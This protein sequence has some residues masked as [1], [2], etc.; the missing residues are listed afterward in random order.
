LNHQENKNMSETTLFG[1]RRSLI[2]AAAA[3]L[4][5]CFLG[6][7]PLSSVAADAFPSRPIRMVVPFPPG[8]GFDSVAR[9]FAEKLSAI[10]KQTVMVDNR[11]GAGGNIGTAEVGRAPRDGYTILFANEILATNPNMYAS[12]PFD[13]IKDFAP[14]AMIATTPLVLA[15]YPGLPAKNLSELIALS[16][17]EPITFGTPGIGTSPHLF[18]ELLNLKTPLKM[19]H[20][21]YRGTAPAINDAMAGQTNAVLTSASAL[22]QQIVGGKL[23]GIAIL[24]DRRSPL[25]PDL[26][27]LAEAGI[28]GLTHDI[29]YAVLAP[30]GTPPAIVA[31]LR[32]ASMTVMR[33]P[34]LSA[35]L[36]KLGFEPVVGDDK[37]VTAMIQKDL[38]RW[39]DVI[40]EAKIQK[41]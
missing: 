26:P 38:K 5:A 2:G 14:I 21:P 27:T 30:A 13:P 7:A 20:I 3:S 6:A 15:T 37:A 32:D 41:E 28:P 16:A 39:K 22:T 19:R 17:K 8:G 33:D 31:Q 40:A 29:W 18:G 36:R 4:A 34:E 35:L 23:R 11:A 1:A 10:L 12:V 24:S 25:V 9:P